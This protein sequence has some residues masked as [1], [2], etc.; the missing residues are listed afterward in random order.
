M[1]KIFT[2]LAA[3]ALAA[4]AATAQITINSTDMPVPT[5]PFPVRAL[6]FAQTNPTTGAN[7]QWHYDTAT[8]VSAT[9]S[10]FPETESFFTSGGIDV[11]NRSTKTFG[12]KFT[13][14]YFQEIDFNSSTVS[15]GGYYIPA[16]AKQNIPGSTTDSLVS[17]GDSAILNI[18][19]D[20]LR[21]PLNYAGTWST[22]S[23][24]IKLSLNVWVP[25]LSLSN[26]PVQHSFQ[27]YESDNIA[28]WGKMRV[29]NSNGKSI[30]YDVLMDKRS[31]YTIDSFLSAGS[32]VPAAAL[33][34]LGATQ[35]EHRDSSARAIFFRKGTYCPLASFSY[36]TDFTFTTQRGIFFDST[37]TLALGVSEVGAPAFTTV[38]YPNPATGDEVNMMISG[39]NAVRTVEYFIADMTG[40]TIQSGTANLSGNNVNIQF[41]TT[42]A[43]GN[44]MLNVADKQN[45]FEAK[46]EF[47]VSK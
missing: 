46:E 24:P 3:T 27:V 4:T 30:W 16:F 29:Y 35:G 45:G 2:L 12:S 39:K 20:L 28:G 6:S 32:A 10:Y 47:T 13:Y 19:T 1:T 37:V 33:T 17:G 9:L 40:K 11:Y 7:Q 21:F 26:Y 31:S 22:T 43:N 14:D 36:G 42:L 18:K 41:N 8:T 34:Y 25:S 23:S 44:Y 38:L 15:L 5:G